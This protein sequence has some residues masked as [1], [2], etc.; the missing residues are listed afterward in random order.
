M[1]F[2][3]SDTDGLAINVSNSGDAIINR[4]EAQVRHYHLELLAQNALASVAAAE[5]CWLGR[6][7]QIKLY[8]HTGVLRLVR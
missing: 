1:T 2:S 8:E 7:P 4:L 3:T 6:L 5:I